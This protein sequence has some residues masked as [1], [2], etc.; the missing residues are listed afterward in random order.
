[1]YRELR[2]ESVPKTDRDDE[3]LMG[4]RRVKDLHRVSGLLTETYC[5]IGIESGAGSQCRERWTGADWNG[6][7]L[8]W[9]LFGRHIRDPEKRSEQALTK[10]SFREKQLSYQLLIRISR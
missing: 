9:T 10:L 7:G 1:M 5:S 3:E 2:P 8:D 4:T 6:T